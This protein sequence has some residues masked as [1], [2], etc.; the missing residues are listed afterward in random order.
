[1]PLSKRQLLVHVATEYDRKQAL[2]PGYNL[3]AL[4]QYLEAIHSAMDYI[5]LGHDPRQVL[6]G[7]FSGRLLDKMLRALGEPKSTREEQTG[8]WIRRTNY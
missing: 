4:P 1:M 2:K 6:V 7:H 8:G 5:D 3:Y